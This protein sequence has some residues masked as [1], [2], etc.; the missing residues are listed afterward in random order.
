MNRE[1]GVTEISVYFTRNDEIPG[2]RFE[3]PTIYT[4]LLIIGSPSF[5]VFMT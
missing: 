2:V 4:I 1:T 3:R 5:R